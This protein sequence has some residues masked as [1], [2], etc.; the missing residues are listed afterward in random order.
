MYLYFITIDHNHE[1]LS[2]VSLNKL[3]ENK[4]FN[5]QFKHNLW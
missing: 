1:Q 2:H 3:D 4:N 5:E